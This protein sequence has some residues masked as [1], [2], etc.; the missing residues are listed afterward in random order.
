MTISPKNIFSLKPS[1]P[2]L[3]VA[4]VAGVVSLGMGAADSGQARL[5]LTVVVDGLDA[6]YLGLLDSHFGDGGFRRLQRDGAVLTADYGPG[7]DAAAATVTL[8]TGAAPSTSG[9]ASST[10]YDRENM[11]VTSLFRD[12]EVLGN[13]TAVG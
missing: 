4:L 7:L 5:L 9:V 8:V 12:P 10:R 1:V 13:F 2:R 6:D 3:F 11:R